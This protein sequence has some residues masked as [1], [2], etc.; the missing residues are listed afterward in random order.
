MTSNGPQ[1]TDRL[2]S[3]KDAAIFLTELGLA[4]SAQ[5]LARLFSEGRG[6][7]CMRI[8]RRA[9]Y[10][11]SDLVAYYRSRASAPRQCSSEPLRPLG[12]DDLPIPAN[13][14]RTASVIGIEPQVP[15]SDGDPT[16]NIRRT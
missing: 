3:R 6:P 4:I 8:G 1:P 13:D 15:R 2:L 10:K 7:S 14:A 16:R 12:P 11:E 5:T 9:M